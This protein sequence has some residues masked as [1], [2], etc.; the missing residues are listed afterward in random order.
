MGL[1][2]F[3]SVNVHKV[4]VNR[5]NGL[6]GLASYPVNYIDHRV[7]FQERQF[8]YARKYYQTLIDLIPTYEKK[9]IVDG[10]VTL[11]RAYA[12]I[13]LC[14]YYLGKN[15]EATDL[16]KKA[17][18]IE[19]RHFWFNYNLAVIYFQSGDYETALFYL[20]D[21]F[22]L[23]TEKLEVSMSLDYYDL[24]APKVAEQY[25]KVGSAQF[26]KVIVHSYKLAILAY[27]RL[28][29]PAQMKTLSAAAIQSGLANNDNFFYYYAGLTSQR[30]EVGRELFDLMVNPSLYF[31]SIGQERYLIQKR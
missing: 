28:K 3:L 1:I 27:E 7:P 4:K 30:P 9:G 29:E 20:K 2:V 11:S 14:D 16:F 8:R 23:N 10:P 31:A 17:L 26:Y 22:S 15:K 13:A 25:K 6:E 5:L 21:L 12:M 24:W 18:K 19:P